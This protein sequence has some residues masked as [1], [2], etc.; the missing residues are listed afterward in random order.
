MKIYVGNLSFRTTQQELEDLFTNY[1]SV[2]EAAVVTDRETGRSRGFGFVTMPEDSEAN[3]AIEAL[4]GTEIEGRTLTVNEAR[5][6]TDRPR[7]GGGGGY[8]GGRGGG[9]GGR[10]RW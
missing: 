3:A 9:G 7:S 1:G 10:D 8:G 5:P 6:K 2:Q 4:N